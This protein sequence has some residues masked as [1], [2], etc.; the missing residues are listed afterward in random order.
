MDRGG[1]MVLKVGVQ[2]RERSQRKKILLTSHLL[3]T[4]GD[5][6]QNIAPFIIVIMTCK[7]LHQIKLHNS[8]L[9]DICGETEA[10]GHVLIKMGETETFCG[11]IP[12]KLGSQKTHRSPLQ[13]DMHYHATL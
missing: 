8:G 10:V 5:M 3:L 9:C 2:F 12:R 13:Q 1:A 6:K 4:W 7:R 11:F